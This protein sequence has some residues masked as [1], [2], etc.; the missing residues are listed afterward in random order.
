MFAIST[1]GDFVRGAYIHGNSD[2]D[3]RIQIISS[4]DVQTAYAFSPLSIAKEMSERCD[5]SVLT[6]NNNNDDDDNDND[7]NVTNQ[8]YDLFLRLLF[9]LCCELHGKKKKLLCLCV[10]FFFK[11]K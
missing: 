3:P 7:D 4:I 9:R 5:R 11:K 2:T 6:N 8:Q 10:Y 1:D